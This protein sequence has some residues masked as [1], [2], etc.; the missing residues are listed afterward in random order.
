[1]TTTTQDRIL[2]EIRTAI[3]STLDDNGHAL[4]LAIDKNYA[5]T[6]IMGA[7]RSTDLVAPNRM[8]FEFSQTYATFKPFSTG[9][10][11]VSN[12]QRGKIF[13]DYAKGP[14]PAAEK[15]AAVVTF[16]ASL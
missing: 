7:M 15:I 10:R 1:M 8:S 5:N 9:G 3:E 2:E 13:V 16:L 6:G 12:S 11:D 4:V 14:D